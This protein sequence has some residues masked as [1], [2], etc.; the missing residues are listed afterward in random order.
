MEMIEQLILKRFVPSELEQNAE[1][2][3]ITTLENGKDSY[4]FIDFLHYHSK[5][6]TVSNTF[7][8]LVDTTSYYFRNF[9]R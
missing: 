8:N 4:H 1:I 2:Q 6:Q 3:L 5:E 7:Y 9:F